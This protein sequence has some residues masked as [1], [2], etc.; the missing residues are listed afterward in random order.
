MY[1]RTQKLHISHPIEKNNRGIIK[2][3]KEGT[4]NCPTIYVKIIS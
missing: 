2:I 4:G 3:K 1:T